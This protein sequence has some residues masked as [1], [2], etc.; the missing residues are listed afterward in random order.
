MLLKRVV[1]WITATVLILGGCGAA[2]HPGTAAT[3]QVT[4]VPHSISPAVNFALNGSSFAFWVYT[5]SSYAAG[6][7]LPVLLLLHGNG[8]QG[9]DMIHVWEDFAEQKGI[10]LV[11]P[12]LNYNAGAEGMVPQLF[13]QLFDT[14]KQSWQFDTHRVYV[15]GVSAGGYLSYDA[16]TLL[17]DR[18][19]AAGVFAAIITPDYYWIVNH[20]VRKTPIAIYIGDHDQFFTLAETRS[21]R[22]FL[23]ANG[24]PVHYTEYVNQDH[25]YGLISAKVNSDFWS[26]ASQ[27]SLP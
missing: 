5:P 3:S 26:Y 17:S 7:P 18:F 12:T 15:F 10:L 1:G 14:F 27:F 21:T 20:A 4:V 23:L 6:A 25:N 22:D 24:F 13:P 8:G 19:A 9:L 16:A 11:A 2:S